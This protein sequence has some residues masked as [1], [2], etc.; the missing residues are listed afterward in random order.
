M[1]RTFV[2]AAL[3]AAVALPSGTAIAAERDPGPA[4]LLPSDWKTSSDMAWTTS[5]DSTG[6]HLLTADSKSGYTWRTVASLA[7]PGFDTDRWIGN[8]CLT[9]SGKRAVVVYAPR[10]FTNSS[11]LFQRGG[12]A[13]FVDLGSGAVT[14]LPFTV[15]LAYHNPGCGSGET[16]AFGAQR[17]GRTRLY[18]ADAVSGSVLRRHELAGQVTS[19]VP[20]GKEII[21]A[22]GAGLIRVDTVGG[23]HTLATTYGTPYDVRPESGGAVAYVEAHGEIGVVKEVAGGSVREVAHGPV[24]DVGLAAGTGGKVFLVGKPEV[25]SLPKA[26]TRVD[27]P[28]SSDV[29]T[30]GAV[31]VS[32]EEKQGATSRG[33]VEPLQLRVDVPS[34]QSSAEVTVTPLAVPYSGPYA[35]VPS[36]PDATCAVPRN[37]TAT[38]VY[39]P[40][41]KQVEWAADLAVQHALTVNRQAGW[42]NSGLPA[43]T[44]QGMFPPPGIVTGTGRIPPPIMLGVIAQESN[45]WQASGHALEGEYGN[46]LVGN[47]YGRAV[48]ADTGGGDPWAIDWSKSDCGYGVAQITDGMRKTDT[49]RTANQKRAIALDYASN[50]AAGVK[51]LEEK[52]NL[53]WNSGIRVNSGNPRWIENWFA[54]LWAYNTGLQPRDSSF[55]NTTG[56]T[57]SPTCT[58]SAG[59]W[60][61]GWANNPMNPDYPANRLPFLEN[62]QDDARHPQDW[63]YPEKVMG[64]AAYPIVKSDPWTNEYEAGY[65][66]AWWT[67]AYFRTMIKPPRSLFCVPSVNHCD[68][69][70]SNACLLMD[71]HCWWNGQATYKPSCIGHLPNDP[72]TEYTSCGQ[73][74]PAYLPGAAEPGDWE[75][76]YDPD[77]VKPALPTT[78]FY[79]DDVATSV[80][81]LRQTYKQNVS[82]NPKP[83]TNSGTFALD[84][85]QDAT[86]KYRSKIDFHQI[87]GGFGGHFWFAHTYQAA[88]F[89]VT[90]TWQL[91]Q[92]LNSWARVLAYIPDHGSDTQQA[93]YTIDTGDGTFA[94]DRIINAK[95]YWKDQKG[96]WVSLG[97][98]QFAGVPKV[99]LSNITYDGN[100]SHDIAFDAIAIQPLAAKPKNFVVSMGD[101]YA[102]GEGASTDL[103]TGSDYSYETNSDGS[104]GSRRNACHR[105]LYSWTSWG[106]L[107]DNVNTYVRDRAASYDKDLD[108]QAVACSGAQTEHLLPYQG[109]K[110]AW[111]EG[112][113]GK[114]GEVSQ[115]ETGFLDSNTTLVTLS[116]GGNDAKWGDAFRYCLSPTELD[117]HRSTR[118]GDSAPFEYVMLDNI[119][120]K[121]IPS[122]KTVLRNIH[123]K[124][125]NAK[126]VLMGYPRLVSANASCLRSGFVTGIMGQFA[127]GVTPTESDFLT[128]AAD[129]LADSERF[130]ADDLRT[131]EGIQVFFA[132]AIPYFDNQGICGNP[133]KI[134]DLVTS[135][136]PGE[137]RKCGDSVLCYAVENPWWEIGMSQQSFHPSRS[138]AYTYSTAFNDLLRTIDQ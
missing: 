7:E 131:N 66:Q 78:A 9:G 102:S 116:I 65:S 54:A 15:S 98:F 59:N 12:F 114:F 4:G 133:Q 32:H 51:M 43:W 89:R 39:Q 112:G 19:A 119:T 130:A 38:Q 49:S 75:K 44:P 124:A 5:G 107:K 42:K 68:P 21:A 79:I 3:V 71:L 53:T 55:G 93:H 2:V 23:A 45:M 126:I 83:F 30:T 127:F 138:G 10:Q 61:L 115:L 88:D 117:C 92:S 34:T 18:L 100:G 69:G 36:D 110:N 80:P 108:Y 109:D 97:V 29:S 41:W 101:S 73:G 125:P 67:D 40:S 84:F 118:P 28:V 121:V 105:S 87:G 1:L 72:V 37:D 11:D 17:A 58:D 128:Y 52:Y 81:S 136:T 33:L 137:P 76:W 60:G 104:D 134:H 6:F 47:F 82:C 90:G 132:N 85:A 22:S 86:G 111:N 91:N 103:T 74:D 94:H 77:C 20:Y 56:C 96:R 113:T 25:T 26:M 70:V 62:S 120:T 14:K 63:P 57:P 24:A 8:V 129:F 123:T 13:A 122:I 64:W 135:L 16:V 99:S 48:T 95:S 106:I 35:S 50:I 46:P 27:A 31:A